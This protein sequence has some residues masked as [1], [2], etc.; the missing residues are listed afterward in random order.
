MKLSDAEYRNIIDYLEQ[1]TTYD[2]GLL[3]AKDDA[4]LYNMKKRKCRSVPIH[5]K[6]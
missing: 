4:Q 2:I 5:C 6:I 3:A 1:H